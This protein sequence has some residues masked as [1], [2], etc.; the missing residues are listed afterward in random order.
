AVPAGHVSHHPVGHGLVGAG[1]V[2][3]LVHERQGHATELGGPVFGHADTS[4]I[5]GDDGG[6]L[7]IDTGA[8]VVGQDG[9]GPYV[10]HRAVEEAQGLGGVQVHAHQ[11]VGAGGGEHV[12][13]QACG[14]GCTAAVLLVLAG[15]AVDVH[16]GGYGFH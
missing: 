9:H 12:R 10:V 1:D 11:S 3:G 15:I 8:H 16:Y 13:H 4:G 6:T 2:A 14:D 5:R 7:R